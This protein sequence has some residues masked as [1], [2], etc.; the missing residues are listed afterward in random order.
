MNENVIIVPHLVISFFTWVQLIF[1]K[2]ILSGSRRV[3]LSALDWTCLIILLQSAFLRWISSLAVID[4]VSHY[5][6]LAACTASALNWSSALL[7]LSGSIT[8]PS[9]QQTF[10]LCLSLL[11]TSLWETVQIMVID[12]T[13][14]C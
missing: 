5:Q 10:T 14:S 4:S 1:T 13:D 3:Q 2:L 8:L 9:L 11:V 6:Y 12:V 7:I